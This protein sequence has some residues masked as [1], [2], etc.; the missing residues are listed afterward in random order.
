M[1]LISFL[2]GIEKQLDWHLAHVCPDC[3]TIQTMSENLGR[4][5]AGLERLD[6]MIGRSFRPNDRHRSRL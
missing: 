5:R 1:Q 6:G 2:A 3:P 4:I